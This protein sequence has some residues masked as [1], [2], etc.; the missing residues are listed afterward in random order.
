MSL[1]LPSCSTGLFFCFINE[2]VCGYKNAALH[3][4]ANTRKMSVSASGTIVS[5]RKSSLARKLEKLGILGNQTS[6][7]VFYGRS[8]ARPRGV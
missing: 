2:F 7:I 8:C 1:F 3:N 4:Y 6:P 5:G